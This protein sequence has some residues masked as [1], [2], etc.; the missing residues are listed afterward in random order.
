MS[1]EP[2]KSY[3]WWD[4]KV[5]FDPEWRVVVTTTAPFETARDIISKV[6]SYDTPMIIYDL[7]NDPRPKTCMTTVSRFPTFIGIMLN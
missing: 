3:Y 7:P 5:N 4:G 1:I 2:I 6:H